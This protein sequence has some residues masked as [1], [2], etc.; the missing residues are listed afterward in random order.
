MN[1]RTLYDNRKYA[2]CANKMD[3]FLNKKLQSIYTYLN[4]PH[5]IQS[6][7]QLIRLK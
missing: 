4:R 1:C 2:S 7:G 5:S 6:I 3:E